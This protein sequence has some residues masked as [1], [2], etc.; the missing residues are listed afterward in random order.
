MFIRNGDTGPDQLFPTQFVP[1]DLAGHPEAVVVIR[2]RTYGENGASLANAED[3]ILFSLEEMFGSIRSPWVRMAERYDVRHMS[4]DELANMA[5]ELYQA[6][7]ITPQ[8]YVLLSEPPFERLRGARLVTP[9]D[10]QG[11]RDWVAEYE[12]HL[13][14][15]IGHGDGEHLEEKLRLLEYL[16]KLDAVGSSLEHSSVR[17]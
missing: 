17:A 11:R 16:E 10:P 13:A 15:A 14:M 5:Y 2:E 12:A 9:E 7:A 3:P 1:G 8:D 4:R 6:K